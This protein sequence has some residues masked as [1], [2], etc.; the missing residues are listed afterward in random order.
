MD[1]ELSQTISKYVEPMTSMDTAKLILGSGT[2]EALIRE[3]AE[4]VRIRHSIEYENIQED[5]FAVLGPEPRAINPAPRSVIK[6]NVVKLMNK[7]I[8]DALGCSR[9]KLHI[10][11]KCAIY[12]YFFD[13]VSERDVHTYFR[14][15]RTRRIIPSHANTIKR[16]P[17]LLQVLADGQRNIF[18]ICLATG[19][20][21]SELKPLGKVWKDLCKNSLTR[22]QY[23]ANVLIMTRHYSRNEDSLAA[24]R[25]LNQLNSSTLRASPSSVARLIATGMAE[26]IPDLVLCLRNAKGK[27][28]DS[29]HIMRITSMLTDM[30]RMADMAGIPLRVNP[31]WSLRRLE[32]EHKIVTRKLQSA[33]YPDTPI[34][35]LQGLE[36]RSKI[37]GE[38]TVIRVLKSQLDVAVEGSTMHHC[39]A[40]KAKSVAN[41]TY[42]V[43]HL[44]YGDGQIATAGFIVSSES[45]MV[46]DY[47]STR[48]SVRLEQHYGIC[49]KIISDKDGS[50]AKLL[51]DICEEVK[52]YLNESQ[53]SRKGHYDFIS[54]PKVAEL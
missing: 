45:V 5:T 41:K 24:L 30:V 18:P 50:K 43:L 16:R 31:N 20:L 26:G 11:L 49:N 48:Y 25:Q 34:G 21:P 46:E 22:N 6:K 13:G 9:S 38:N 19:K 28:G 14:E 35:W 4:E 53:P 17:E 47:I 44:E 27:L 39:V 42:L 40:Y 23:I 33:A 52:D 3:A 36:I 15:G 8:A 51:A 32:E 10:V 7:R 1:G 29:A 12:H 54:L 37:D 2:V